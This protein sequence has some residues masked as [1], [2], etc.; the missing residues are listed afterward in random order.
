MLPPSES[1]DCDRSKRGWKFAPQLKV[2][3]TTIQSLDQLSTNLSPEV[4]PAFLQHLIGSTVKRR[5]FDTAEAG[6]LAKI[7]R[8]LELRTLQCGWSSWLMAQMCRTCSRHLCSTLRSQVARGRLRS[9]LQRRK[10]K[11][12]TSPG[13]VEQP[14]SGAEVRSHSPVLD[15]LTR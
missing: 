14:R 13:Y 9:I 7:E 4:P 5:G 10:R 3:M 1:R 6:A 12:G 15:E 2:N 11:L 8:L